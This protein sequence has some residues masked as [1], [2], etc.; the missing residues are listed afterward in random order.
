MRG[1]GRAWTKRKPG[2]DVPV[3]L[4]LT[5]AVRF[6]L[7]LREGRF[8]LLEF[9]DVVRG[10]FRHQFADVVDGHVAGNKVLCGVQ[11]S[12]LMSAFKALRNTLFQDAFAEITHMV[13]HLLSGVVC[14]D[15]KFF[16]QCV[17]LFLGNHSR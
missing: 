15:S 9:F 11:I 5:L 1:Q 4:L 2:G 14:R 13:Q 7:G 3:R 17:F 16:F 12:I 10:Q 8:E 6:L